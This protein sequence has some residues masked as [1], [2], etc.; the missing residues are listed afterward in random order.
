MERPYGVFSRSFTLP[1]TV[2]SD[3]IHA[4]YVKGVLTI[5]ITKR[6]GAKPKQVPISTG[7]RA[8]GAGAKAAA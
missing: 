7:P 5:E 2:D 8:L 6:A 4:N 3:H 1:Q